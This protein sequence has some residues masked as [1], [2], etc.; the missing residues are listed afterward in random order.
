MT[1]V[2]AAV[3]AAVA[4]PALLAGCSSHPPDYQSIW[5]TT[6]T[7]TAESDDQGERPV[8]IAQYL[9]D[10]GV[11]GQLVD[12][13]DLTDLTVSI[14]TPPGWAKSTNR[15]YSPEAVVIAKDNDYPVAILLVMKLDGDF[16]VAEAIRH[17]NT[18]AQL[19]ENFTELD[20]STADYQGFPS[21]S[22]EGSYDYLARRLHSYNRIVI[23]T[24]AAPAAQRYL[25]QLTVTSLAEE[26]VAHS[27]DVESIIDGFRLA[28][29]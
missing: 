11:K 12:P 14:P 6:T 19:N 20:A 15:H 7:T 8:P 18:D 23:A 25:V 24:G 13:A 29:P 2:R 4:L 9:E 26:T 28:V 1:A 3:F 10:H 17:G 27:D 5:T 22:I 21:S 16:D